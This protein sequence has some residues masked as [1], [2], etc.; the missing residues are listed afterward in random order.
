MVIRCG[1]VVE[2]QGMSGKPE[3]R[4]SRLVVVLGAVM[5]ATLAVLVVTGCG[6]DEDDNGGA[7][8]GGRSAKVDQVTIEDFKFVPGEIVVRAGTKVTWTNKDSANHTA[9]SGPS[10]TPDGAFDTGT[11]KG[12]AS[13]TVTLSKP[14]TFAYFCEFHATMKGRITVE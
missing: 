2:Y 7:Q 4:V 12:G 13:A 11:I 8:S 5:V 1:I 10:P 14:G 9:T 6:Q 3:S